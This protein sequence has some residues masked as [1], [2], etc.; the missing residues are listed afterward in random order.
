MPSLPSRIADAFSKPV[1]EPLAPPDH[2]DPADVALMLREIGI[3][4]VEASQPVQAVE[5]RLLE[6]GAR[7]TSEP[8]QAAVLPTM[9]FIQI[10][11]TVHQ[12]EGWA[13]P[14][15]M[16]GTAARVDEIADR[17]AVGAIAPL[18]AVAAVHAARNR[19]PRFGPLLTALGYALTT[20][21]FGLV[22]D[23]SWQALPAHFFLGL[24]VGLIVQISSRFPNLTPI[25]PTL[26]AVV[27][28]L[29]AIWFV[30][31]VAGDGLLRV[32]SPPL[33]ATLPGMAL[34]VGAIELAGGRIVSGASRTVYGLAQMGLLVYGVVLG[35]RIAGQVPSPAESVAMGPW[36]L[37]LSIVVIA[38]GLYLY[39]SA[40]RGSLIWLLLTIAVAMLSQT[41]AGLV[42]NNGHSGFVAA[43]VG[44]PF[45]MLMSRIKTAPP[46]TVLV[47]A[48]F[49]SLVPGQLTFMSLSRKASGDIAN[50]ANLSV[51][52]A[53][54]VSIALG[55]VVGWT[56]VR[57]VS[58][59]SPRP[60]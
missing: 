53:A 24:V 32:I 4:L 45:A 28:T 48:V 14:S 37:Y 34:V 19:P 2:Y 3:A 36:S 18:D 15:G 33:I 25:V 7:Y 58:G 21:G 6:I 1:P 10:G 56:L 27:V 35:V 41:V 12:M 30:A 22:T 17:A 54:I 5:Q 60:E 57:T 44:I 47:L 40:P 50:T 42:L 11:N 38:V 13:Q 52:A 8:V 49:W 9:L 43:M 26:A 23:P 59:R 31:D 46:S 20:V 16:L 55:T 51:A 29:L 39:L